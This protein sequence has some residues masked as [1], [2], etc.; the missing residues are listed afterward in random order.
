MIY[1]Y[2]RVSTTLQDEENQRTGVDK[3]AKELGVK[4]D[5]YV[6]DK[7]SGV[8]DYNQRNLG[9]MIKKLQED[10]IIIISE[11]SRLSRRVFMLFEIIK[12]LIEKNVHVYS[13]K[14]GYV[15]ENSIQSKVLAFAFGLAAEIERDLIS[16]RT[17]EALAH[18]R[19]MGTRL[20]RPAGAKNKASK[21][22]FFKEKILK[23][24]HKG[25]SVNKLRRKYKV[26][27]K[28]MKDYLEKI[29]IEEINE[30]DGSI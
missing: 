24:Y 6:I 9:K 17:K 26:C 21:L 18:R 11:L 13:V 4:I 20:G 2:L 19:A 27:N 16:A 1:A 28:T 12:K 8:T 30:T 10:D 29:L 7:V 15:L 25:D 23:A 22:D 5:K 14:D 3:K